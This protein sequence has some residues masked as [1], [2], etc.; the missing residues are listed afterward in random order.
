MLAQQGGEGRV[1][2][3]FGEQPQDGLVVVQQ[4]ALPVAFSVPL[5]QDR[6]GPGLVGGRPQPPQVGGQGAGEEG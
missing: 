1:E 3:R 4:A 5:G 2:G 6:G